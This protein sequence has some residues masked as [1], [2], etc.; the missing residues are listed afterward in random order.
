MVTR[1]IDASVIIQSTWRKE[2]RV[3][4]FSNFSII[5]SKNILYFVLH[6]S[7]RECIL[8]KDDEQQSFANFVVNL[9]SR[10]PVW[11]KAIEMTE[12]TQPL[13]S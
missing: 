5:F 10:N 3:V 12:T 1:A 7:S 13:Q 2:V 9:V 11:E 4:F 6:I 8:C